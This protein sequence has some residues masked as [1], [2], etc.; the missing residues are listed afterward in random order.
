MRVGLCPGL[1]Q[2][3]GYVARTFGLQELQGYRTVEWAG[4][5]DVLL[6]S[7]EELEKFLQRYGQFVYAV[8]GEELEEVVGRLL[9]QRGLKLVTAESC[10]GG[11]LSARI[12][13]V[14]GSSSY[15]LG[16]F[17]AYD[18]RLKGDWLGVEEGALR[19]SGAVSEEVCRQMALGALH[20]TGADVSVAI[21][22]ISG[23]GGGTQEKP[24]GLTYIAL[25]DRRQVS[26]RRFVFS[27]SRNENRFVATQWALELLRQYLLGRT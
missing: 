1:E 23:P 12:V 26:V 24:V 10:T 18:N 11:L 3:Q 5:V 16:G 14:P 9:A 21:T 20:K 25:A 13:N 19:S 17:V 7:R 2:V 4:G 15:F 8:G 22:G 6:E 27:G